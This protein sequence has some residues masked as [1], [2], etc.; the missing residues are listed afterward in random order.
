ME[1]AELPLLENIR[2]MHSACK[3]RP[4]TSSSVLAL[5]SQVY[6][7][8]QLKDFGFEFSSNQYSLSRKKASEENFTLVD[9]ERHAPTS[10]TKVSDETKAKVSDIL[11]EFSNSS[12]TISLGTAGNGYQ[13][14]RYLTKPKRD[15]YYEL[16]EK[17]PEIQ[18]SQSKFY[19]LCSKNYRKSQKRTDVCNI[20]A[21][22]EKIKKYDM[23]K[24]N[25]NAS[26]EQIMQLRIATE[27]FE[28]HKRIA[29]EQRKNFKNQI[30]GLSG[31]SLIIIADFKKKFKISGG[32]IE[33]TRD[34]YQKSQISD[35][36][37]CVVSKSGD[38]IQ[39][40]YYNYLSENLSHD[41]LYIIN[42]LKDLLYRS[43]FQEFEEVNL[44][45]DSGPHFKNTDY[46]YLVCLELPQIFSS[47]KFKLNY[48]MENHGKSDVDGRFGV[49]SR[50]FKEIE[51]KMY[52]PS[53]GDLI[54]AFRE[55]AQQEHANTNYKGI[56]DDSGKKLATKAKAE[57]TKSSTSANIQQI[58][59]E[60]ALSN[61]AE[62]MQ[63][64]TNIDEME[65]ILF[66]N[67]V[68][69]EMTAEISSNPESAGLNSPTI[70]NITGDL[71][72]GTA[73]NATDT[74]HAT[75]NTASTVA[76]N[77]QSPKGD[78]GHEKIEVVSSP[79]IKVETPDFL[80]SSSPGLDGSNLR[81]QFNKI[82][83]G[84]YTTID[85]IDQ[86]VKRSFFNREI[87]EE[88]GV[89]GDPIPD[90]SDGMDEDLLLLWNIDELSSDTV[91]RHLKHVAKD[92]YQQFKVNKVK[93]YNKKYR[94][95]ITKKDNK[96]IDLSKNNIKSLTKSLRCY[97]SK[98]ELEY[99]LSKRSPNIIGIQESL[100]T[101]DTNRCN[102]NG[103]TCIESKS[104]V[105]RGGNGL[106]LG[107]KNGFGIK[108][109]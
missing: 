13:E 17:H 56:P 108:I 58:N 103:Y 21:T 4:G 39:R 79:A 87:I 34:F 55:K 95:E 27:E 12:S 51:R 62:L 75:V 49:L 77:G 85:P 93:Q 94:F 26:L 28:V 5:V 50:W 15:I 61:T 40:R 98:L 11:H 7:I 57:A 25:K 69:Q 73:S 45:S 18:L 72:D 86:S 89:I 81:N 9:Y 36:C 32:K 29:L 96:T 3:S 65:V 68:K 8:E 42:C 83:D 16:K 30:A 76:Y 14:I 19:S 99:I 67:E 38:R 107:V 74:V 101:R 102:I 92:T 48:F 104:D 46:L 84:A 22:G 2:K 10:K 20:C 91:R 105:A 71:P 78:T 37:F 88:L 109:Y 66:L 70:I 59:T 23:T 82:Y 63:Q 53:I 6:I 52:L 106:I 31:K 43:E 1:S 41:S 60:V 64:Q 24:G 54:F 90:F 44:W 100:L 33:T 80:L 97:G 47:K 35:L